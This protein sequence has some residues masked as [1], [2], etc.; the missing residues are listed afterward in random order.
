MRRRLITALGLA[1]VGM[2]A[3]LFGGIFY[4]ALM[5]TFLIGAAGNMCIYSAR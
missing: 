5:G 1:A 2:P 3:I 4:Y